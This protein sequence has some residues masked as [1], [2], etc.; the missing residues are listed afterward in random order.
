MVHF[1]EGERRT[2]GPSASLGMKKMA[3][4]VLWYPTQAKTG[5]ESGTQ[6]SLPMERTAGPSASLPQISCEAVGVGEPHA[7]FLT[8]SR[9][10][11]RGWS[12]VQEIRV[13]MTKWRAALTLAP[14]T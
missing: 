9:T 8:E 14:V 10:R 7:A 4:R 2:A 11:S 1:R 3:H 12:H 13:G 5:L 6:P